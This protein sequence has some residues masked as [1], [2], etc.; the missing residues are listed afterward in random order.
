MLKPDNRYINV[1]YG[2]KKFSSG[3]CGYIEFGTIIGMPDNWYTVSLSIGKK[4]KM[5]KAYINSDKG[6]NTQTTNI[7]SGIEPL[8]WAKEC[9]LY[10]IEMKRQWKYP[11]PIYILV[12]G[13]DARRR[14]IYKWALSKIG[15]VE[16]RYFGCY[17]LAYKIEGDNNNV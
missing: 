1:F 14:K 17:G 3:Y 8:L 2:T 4:K 13:E 6:S 10:F 7:G 16:G 11:Y 15:F 9:I 12:Y 5:A